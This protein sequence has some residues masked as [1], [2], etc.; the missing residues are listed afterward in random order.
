M[1]KE[2]AE[3]FNYYMLAANFLDPDNREAKDRLITLIAMYNLPLG[4][5]TN[6][7]NESKY[8]LTTLY[9][10]WLAM[11]N[12]PEAFLAFGVSRGSK[13]SQTG[14]RVPD[15]QGIAGT[16]PGDMTGQPDLTTPPGGSPMFNNFPGGLP[17]KSSFPVGLPTGRGS[18]GR[19]TDIYDIGSPDE[20]TYASVAGQ[21]GPN[22]Q[23]EGLTPEGM[24][25]VGSSLDQYWK[26]TTIAK[27]YYLNPDTMEIEEIPTDPRTGVGTWS[28]D[29]H[30]RTIEV[31]E[32]DKNNIP[33][34]KMISKIVPG[35]QGPGV[36]RNQAG[37]MVT[38][39]PPTA[40]ERAYNVQKAKIPTTPEDWQ[41]LE[42]QQAAD[43]ERLDDYLYQQEML[44]DR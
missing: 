23:M 10:Q 11:G 26:D 30:T 7:L 14:G 2:G 16:S 42:R 22:W 8:G 5:S 40:A 6:T 20:N 32:L 33:T 38:V 17:G 4:A 3:G 37:E 39:R 28:T 35:Y 18:A 31:P 9:N 43:L 41:K 29:L 21:M 25:N 24:A 19:A 15:A 13:R 36:G 34:G 1:E 12:S 44:I 27:G